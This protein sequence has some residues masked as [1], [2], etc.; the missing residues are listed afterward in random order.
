MQYMYV[1]VTYLGL[2]FVL[3]LLLHVT[4]ING[5]QGKIFSEFMECE[6]LYFAG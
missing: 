3:K 1:C 4:N 6:K 2:K 5:M